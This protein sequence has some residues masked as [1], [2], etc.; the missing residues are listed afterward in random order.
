MLKLSLLLSIVGIVTAYDNGLGNRPQM[1]WNTWNKYGCNINESVILSTAEKMSEL[2]LKDYGYEYIIIDDCFALKER[3]NETKQMVID[4]L[5]F[6][7][8]MRYVADKVHEL[9]FKFGMYSSA[10]KYTCAGYPGSLHHEEIDADTFVNEWDIDYLKYDNCFNEGYSGTPRISYERY[11]KMAEA[12]KNTGKPVFYSLCQ[13]GEDAVWNWG[14]TVSNSWRISGDIY[15][16]F[17][18]YDDRC[19]CESYDC[20]KIPGHMCSMVNIIEKAI[21]LGQKAGPDYGWNDLD[22][23]EVGN[24][25]MTFEEYKSHFTLWSILKSPLLLGNDVTSMSDEDFGIITNKEVIA[26]NQ[27]L[28]SPGNRVTKKDGVS[29]FVNVLSDGSFVVTVFNSRNDKKEVLIDFEDVFMTNKGF[30]NS[31]FNSKDLWTNETSVVKGNFN[32]TVDPHAVKI[33]KWTEKK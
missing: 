12:L 5:K 15:D 18:K 33:W 3:D 11:N 2:G 4:Y 22:M 6:P 10:G 8:G 29:V 21:P 32:V 24:G 25:G 14:S 16:N 1:G 27:D 23:L 26:V 19:P 28:S 13:W 7:N 31:S 20:D 30:L 9:G 17:D